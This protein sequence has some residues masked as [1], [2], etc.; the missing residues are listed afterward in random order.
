V[1][2]GNEGNVAKEKIGILD[3]RK[4]VKE[5]REDLKDKVLAAR[6]SVT[7]LRDPEKGPLIQK[8]GLG[9]THAAGMFRKGLSELAQY[10]P[11]FN[12]AGPHVIEDMAIWPNATQGE[13]AK[14]RKGPGDGLE[15]ESDGKM[16]MQ[17]FKAFA[18]QV[19]KTAAQK[20]QLG[21]DKGSMEMER[22]HEMDV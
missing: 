6:D 19:A 14:A 3:V 2:P 18:E 7:G 12:Q 4:I 16:T 1:S 22:Q 9:A 10:L 8:P 13:I 5:M 15:Q 17:Q 11:A 20:M 21:Q